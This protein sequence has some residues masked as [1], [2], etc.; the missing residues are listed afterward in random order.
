MVGETESRP[1]QATHDRYPTSHFRLQSHWDRLPPEM[2]TYIVRLRESQSL[3]ERRERES[4]RELCNEIRTFAKVQ[5]KW[6]LGALKVK[7]ETCRLKFCPQGLVP[8]THQK[9]HMI[10]SGFYRDA[11]NVKREIFLGYSFNGAYHRI[12]VVKTLSLF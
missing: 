5:A 2:Q 7:L 8:G 4:W 3:I 12:D 6:G 10:V 11:Q 1:V 9:K